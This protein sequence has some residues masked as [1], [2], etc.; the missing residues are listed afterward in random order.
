MKLHKIRAL[1][2][3]LSGAARLHFSQYGEDVL[4]HKRFRK[5][6]TEHFYVDVGAHHPYH[7]SN[8]AY[9]WTL[10]W[11]GVNVD[12][13]SAVIAAF[14]ASRPQD[15][16][17]QAAVVSEEAAATSSSITFYSSKDIDNCAT[18]DPDVARERGLTQTTTVPCTSL[19]A[20]VEQAH[21]RFPGRFG[22]LNIDI[23]GLD[24]QVIQNIEAW[25]QKPQIV[26]V[27]IY[28]TTIPDVL[29]TRTYKLLTD[30]GYGFTERLGH[31]AVFELLGG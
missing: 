15:L 25:P 22:F 31:T 20:I 11:S 17:L 4:L 6:S 19:T 28:G 9:L 2:T 16:N 18:C 30:A 29:G 7:L 3:L 8:T 14:N 1:K 21:A 13:S 24:D 12:A 10:G 26:M 27:E 5:P 23:E